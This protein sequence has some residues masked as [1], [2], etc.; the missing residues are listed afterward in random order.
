MSC[1]FKIRSECTFLGY[2][3]RL[4]ESNRPLAEGLLNGMLIDSWEC[5]TQ[6][7]TPEMEAEFKRVSS[8]SL[9]KWLPALFGYVIKDHETTSK[10]LTDWRKTL[11]DLVDNNYYGQM[12]TLAK[13]SGLSVAYET[14]ADDV[15]PGDI[16][17]YFK[18]ADVPMCEFWQPLSSG[19]VGSLNFKPIKPTASAARM[20]G[21]P[22][23]AAEAFTSFALTR[24]EH[25]DMLKEVAN[26]NSVQGVSHYVFHTYNHNPQTPFLAPGTSFGAGIGTPFLRGRT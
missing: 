19:L 14:A 10:F 4:S 9:R 3:G 2:I 5:H 21:K 6:S 13:K 16:L 23:V 20:Y 17:E 1:A 18:H 8:Y 15:V 11:S 22:R 25:L 26:I 24:D 12:A 7:W